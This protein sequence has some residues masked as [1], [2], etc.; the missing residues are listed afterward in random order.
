MLRPASIMNP[1]VSRAHSRKRREQEFDH[2]RTLTSVPANITS[3]ASRSVS[4]DPLSSAKSESEAAPPLEGC[5]RRDDGVGIPLE[6][7]GDGS[8]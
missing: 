3:S 8:C 1:R 6:R 2:L 5:L 4:S 7:G